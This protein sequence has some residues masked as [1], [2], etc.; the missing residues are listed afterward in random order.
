MSHDRDRD[1]R[2][3][4]RG[5]DDWGFFGIAN[6]FVVQPFY[7]PQVVPQYLTQPAIY[8]P[9]A[10]VVCPPCPATQVVTTAPIAPLDRTVTITGQN[11]VLLGGAPG[12]VTSLGFKPRKIR[13][14]KTRT[15]VARPDVPFQA[16]SLF[17]SHDVAKH[18]DIVEMRVGNIALLASRDPVPAEMYASH[19]CNGGALIQFPPLLPGQ[20]I[21][22]KLKNRS[23][24]SRRFRGGLNGVAIF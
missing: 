23:G 12:I 16:T 20:H 1:R 6:P 24:S 3:W 19:G 14:H 13:G 7:A 4:R 11:A 17:I 5:W 8:T 18:F 9:P 15:V 22:L 10:P 21:F 2:R